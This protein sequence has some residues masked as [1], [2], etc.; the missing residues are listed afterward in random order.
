M[1]LSFLTQFIDASKVGGWARAG[2]AALIGI[3]IAKWPVLG[4]VLDPATQA[5]LA[6]AVS[7]AVV[8]VW[9]QLTKTP[10]AKVAAVNA[11]P[12]SQVL[13]VVV[14]ST[15]SDGVLAA[16]QDPTMTKVMMT[17]PALTAAIAAA[18]VTAT[19]LAPKVTP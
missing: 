8:G 14:A 13:G 1:N 9:S 17:T 2:V 5:A 19:P 18:P 15:A 16:A 7:G 12:K 3:G 6:L 11:L 4:T 10:A